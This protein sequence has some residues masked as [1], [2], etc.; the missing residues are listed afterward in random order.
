MRT[1]FVVQSDLKVK[2]IEWPVFTV[3]LVCRGFVA[4]RDMNIIPRPTTARFAGLFDRRSRI[5]L[6]GRMNARTGVESRFL[7]RRRVEAVLRLRPSCSPL[8]IPCH[9]RRMPRLPCVYGGQK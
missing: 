3:W 1:P 2:V 8:L 9:C 6:V 7:I 5:M 4:G